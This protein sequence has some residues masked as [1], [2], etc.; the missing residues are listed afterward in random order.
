MLKKSN[1]HPPAIVLL[2]RSFVM[3]V[4]VCGKVDDTI[5]FFHKVLGIVVFDLF[6]SYVYDFDLSFSW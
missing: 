4:V 2:I 3:L 6:F 5:I 1:L